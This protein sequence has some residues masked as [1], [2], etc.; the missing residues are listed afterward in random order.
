M[1]KATCFILSFLIFAT[2]LFAIKEAVYNAQGVKVGYVEKDGLNTIYYDINGNRV[3][4]RPTSVNDLL[5]EDQRKKELIRSGVGNTKYD[6]QA[7]SLDELNQTLQIIARNRSNSGSGYF[8]VCSNQS[9]Q[10]NNDTSSSFCS[11]CGASLE[12]AMEERR[13]IISDGLKKYLIFCVVGI[14][15]M[16][17]LVPLN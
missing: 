9:C 8:L 11:K 5:E 2:P 10:Y 3:S 17:I 12:D 14:G 15:L 6:K 4:G 13:Q 16:L 1:R 7:E